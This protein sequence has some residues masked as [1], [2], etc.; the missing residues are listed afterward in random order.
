MSNTQTVLDVN[1]WMPRAKTMFPIN[2]NVKTSFN[3]GDLVPVEYFEL[4]P[5]DN[6]AF[7]V[8]SLIRVVSPFIKAPMEILALDVKVFKVPYRILLDSF[9][10]VMGERDD[11]ENPDSDY[12]IPLINLEIDD[13]GGGTI[14]VPNYAKSI[15]AYLG[16]PLPTQNDL[17]FGRKIRNINKLL[18][19]AYALIWNNE[20]RNQN[21]Q[22]AKLIDLSDNDID[23]IPEDDVN[24][25][26][27]GSPPDKYTGKL[28]KV[29]RVFDYFSSAFPDTQKGV[30]V[31]L[32]LTGD[33]LVVTTDANITTGLPKFPLQLLDVD[34]AGN[35]LGTPLGLNIN[36][37]SYGDTTGFSSGGNVYPS[38]LIAKMD[39]VT[40]VGINQIR[41]AEKVQKVREIDLIFGTKYYESV[42]NYF[43]VNSILSLL[44]YPE[45][46]GEYSSPIM[47]SQVV[48]TSIGLDGNTPQ[49]NI[50]G[51]SVV[52]N[53][54]G[55][56]NTVAYEHCYVIVMVNT[57]QSH[58][59]QQGVHKS[60][61]RREKFD[62][63]MPPMDGLGF[64]PMLKSEIYGYSS[65]AEANDLWGFQPA[66]ER[67]RRFDNKIT[68]TLNSFSKDGD[69]ND[70]NLA[71]WHMGDDYLDV[72][73]FNEEWLLEKADYLD[74]TLEVP[75]ALSDNYI[76]DINFSGVKVSSVS[77][78]G[79]PYL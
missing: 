46:I 36:G 79:R 54:L 78:L 45:K 24:S 61:N 7:T 12:K 15:L 32:P 68:G 21:Y 65:D 74:R 19:N 70:N 72:P 33:A 62:F 35:H 30:E 10:K 6:L 66:F 3:H 77:P 34:T 42:N 69:G 39:T 64:Q 76:L 23:F 2:S 31:G 49:G 71:V 17:D 55:Y 60:F 63:Y 44:D 27:N 9:K 47:I 56:F 1:Y 58:T 40:S 52:A 53:A 20:Y 26:F 41:E 57:R 50:A 4:L 67:Y 18:S 59:Y 13:G 22:Q 25:V 73:E 14:V 51:Y 43:G 75:S 37:V 11:Y 48:Q 38:N 29:N 5:G 28:A 16:I 8:E